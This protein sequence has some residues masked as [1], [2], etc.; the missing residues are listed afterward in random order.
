M[1]L[2]S[3]SNA[4]ASYFQFQQSLDQYVFFSPLTMGGAS[5]RA[6]KI[7]KDLFLPFFCVV[8]PSTHDGQAIIRQIENLRTTCTVVRKETGSGYAN[9]RP[10]GDKHKTELGKVNSAFHQVLIIKNLHV[11]YRVSQEMDDKAPSIYIMSIRQISRDTSNSSGLYKV[12]K[13]AFGS[14]RGGPQKESS[15]NIDGKKVY[16]NGMSETV[17]DAMDHA[18]Y[19]T[20][21]NNTLLFYCP[22]TAVDELGPMGRN[23]KSR[24][25]T[26]TIDKL[27]NILAINQKASRGVSW[28][29]D[30]RGAS[31]LTEAI[32]QVSGDLSAHSFRLINPI[33]NT[34]RL[35][36]SLTQKKA[37][38]EGEF[39]K[40]NQNR[41]SLMA[42]G[43]QKD[44][45]LQAIGKLPAGKNYDI[46]TRRNIVNAI[47]GLSRFGEKANAAKTKLG[48][49]NKT[50]LQSLKTAGVFRK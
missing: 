42:L 9:N 30:G 10:Q 16:I 6:V 49:A 26:T 29:V 2:P 5:G 35:I 14:N 4:S 47:D 15:T 48:S 1:S 3:L 13:E 33:A 19:A 24:V 46:I 34:A 17:E 36:E 39:F 21:D 27:R 28:Y 8:D 7:H 11:H 41:A 44:D 40:Y 23:E 31:I 43:M 12:K 37:K 25:T 20:D 22:A 18:R 45:L 50:F 38:F 32:K